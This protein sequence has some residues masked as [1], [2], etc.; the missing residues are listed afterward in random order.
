M[1]T[2][3]FT[4]ATNDRLGINFA[5]SATDGA[6]G[7]SSKKERTPSAWQVMVLLLQ[8]T[9]ASHVTVSFLRRN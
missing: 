8:N 6:T 4:K 1:R 9:Y 7:L 3:Q 5:P 2:E